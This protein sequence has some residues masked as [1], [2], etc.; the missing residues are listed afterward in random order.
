M[1]REKDESNTK[2]VDQPAH[3]HIHTI[4]IN[5]AGRVVNDII[6]AVRVVHDKEPVK[7]YTAYSNVISKSGDSV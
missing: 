1:R 6:I 3:T 2:D 7:S 5:I 4:Y